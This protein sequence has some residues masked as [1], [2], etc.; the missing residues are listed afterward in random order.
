MMNISRIDLY[1]SKIC[2]IIKHIYNIYMYC[3]TCQDNLLPGKD[4]RYCY[5]CYSVERHRVISKL[6]SKNLIGDLSGKKILVMSEGKYESNNETKYVE[7]AYFFNKIGFVKTLDIEDHATGGGEEMYFDY[8]ENIEDMK[9]I[10]SDSYDAVVMNHVLSAVENDFTALSEVSRILNSNGTLI[11]TDGIRVE[12]KPYTALKNNFCRRDYTLNDLTNM[13]KMY[14]DDVNVI[15][16][17]DLIPNSKYETF[18]C[19][20]NK[21]TVKYGSLT[22]YCHDGWLKHIIIVF[23][24]EKSSSSNIEAVLQKLGYNTIDLDPDRCDTDLKK[25]TSEQII[26]NINSM[27]SDFPILDNIDQSFN[28]FIMGT[29]YVD[30]IKQIVNDYPGAKIII[31]DIKDDFI[32]NITQ[33]L[34]NMK[35]E[36][37]RYDLIKFNN[38]MIADICNLEGNKWKP[39]CKFLNQPIPDEDFP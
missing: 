29:H 8:Y 16:E 28:A 33:Q 10:E 17:D 9:S 11:L 30:N 26:K 31:T 24:T 35:K 15:F 2:Y 6:Y 14:F 20:L 13:L 34:E 39:F 5:R 32:N 27:Q 22:P 38:F 25:Q 23:N 19:K 4:K 21:K 3:H 12:T 37:A 18:I 1:Y 7:T 36:A